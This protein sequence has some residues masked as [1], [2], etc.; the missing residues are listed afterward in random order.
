MRRTPRILSLTG[1][2]DVLISGMVRDKAGDLYET[3]GFAKTADFGGTRVTSDDT[4]AQSSRFFIAKYNSSGALMWL[5]TKTGVAVPENTTIDGG[6]A[7]VQDRSGNLYAVANFQSAHFTLSGETLDNANGSGFSSDIALLKFTPDGNLVWVQRLGG[8]GDDAFN[9]IAIGADDNLYAAGRSSSAQLTMG[10]FQ[11]NGTPDGLTDAPLLASFDTS[12][13]VRWA[14]LYPGRLFAGG[15]GGTGG[16][17]S[18]LSLAL[19][20]IGAIY[21]SGSLQSDTAQIGDSLIVD[22]GAGYSAIVAK[23]RTDGSMQWLRRS[24]ILSALA[25]AAIAVSGNSDPILA[26]S[27]T[28][29]YLAFAGLAIQNPLSNTTSGIA[30]LLSLDGAGTGLWEKLATAKSSAGS[31]GAFV[32]PSIFAAAGQAIYLNGLAAGDQRIDYAGSSLPLSTSEVNLFLMKLDASGNYQ[33]VVDGTFEGEGTGTSL[34]PAPDGSL[35][36]AGLFGSF[37]YHLSFGTDS[38]S[39]L[40]SIASFV[41][42]LT[43]QPLSVAPSTITNFHL[44]AFPNPA[45]TVL[46]LELGAIPPSGTCV[47]AVYDALGR[48]LERIETSDASQIQVPCAAL[49]PGS[50]TYRVLAEGRLA[51]NGNF[52]VR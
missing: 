22:T 32:V 9:G 5:R 16:D 7:L 43:D 50:Y 19:D 42:H 29:P 34:V 35:Y 8:T 47:V 15:F 52:I 23:F 45:T 36:W 46:T 44:T 31:L 3:G 41:M 26:V 28:A 18:F 27:F 17:D 14:S 21:V 10:T 11:L 37:V 12:G 33:W 49:R 51:T 1:T 20:S 30:A 40:D 13:H 38:L 4:D 2:T 6:S 48:E 39:N 25:F 24:N